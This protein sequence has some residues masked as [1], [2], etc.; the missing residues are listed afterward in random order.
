[1]YNLAVLAQRG[2]ALPLNTHSLFN[3]SRLDER[4]FVVEKILKRCFLKKKKKSMSS[5]NNE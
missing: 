1:M 5:H 4:D 3:V 2:Y